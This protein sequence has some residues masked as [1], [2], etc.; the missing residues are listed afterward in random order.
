M[1]HLIAQLGLGLLFGCGEEVSNLAK[2]P[3]AVPA[4]RHLRHE[5]EGDTITITGCHKKASGSLIIPRTIEGKSVAKIQRLAFSDCI[6]LTKVT[7]PDSL[8]SIG[9]GAFQGCRSLK[10]ITIPDGV[11]S[12]GAYTFRSCTN[13]TSITIGNGVTSIGK[14][15]FEQ[16]SGLTSITIPDS[17][18][19]IE[20]E[21]FFTCRGLITVTFLGDVPK[22]EDNAFEK[23][24]PASYRKPDAK[25]WGDTLAGR[26]VKLITEK[27]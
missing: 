22:I 20:E 27:P 3:K 8:T 23:S 25:G 11:T 16:C 13:L 24:S 1:K 21:A 12:I 4:S 7:I 6:R 17:V 14:N 26:P 5:V 15:A 19:S 18:T 2:P 9:E 10:S